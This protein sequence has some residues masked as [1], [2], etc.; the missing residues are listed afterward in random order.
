ME[1]CSPT[2]APNRPK[3]EDLSVGTLGTRMDGAPG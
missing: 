2:H 3:D 1:F